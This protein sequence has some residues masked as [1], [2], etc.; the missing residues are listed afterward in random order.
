[1]DS[2]AIKQGMSR[3]GARAM[4]KATGLK[5]ADIAKP[6]I[7]VA[8]TWTDVTPCSINQRQVAEWVKR[9]VREAGGTPLEF[10]TI[11]VT[12]GICMG[13]EGM[14][15][16]LISREVVADSIELVVRG[17][18]LDGVVAISGCDKTIPGTVMALLRLDLPGLM[19][20]SGSILPGY[21]NGKA[22]T[23]QDV[24]E[25]IGACAAGKIGE[26]ELKALEDNACPGAGACGGQFTANTM[27][28]AMTL[29]GIS[30]MGMSDIP[31]VDPDK[32]NAAVEAGRLVMKLLKAG[33]TPRK[34]VTRKAVENAITAVM[35]SG[36]STNGVLHL[37]AIAREAGLPLDLSD[38]D[39]ISKRSPIITDLKPWGKYVALDVQK[40]GGVRLFTKRLLDGGLL[41]DELTVTGRR[42]S[43]EAA[44]AKETPGQQV[45]LTLEKPY[46][47]EGGIHIL[48]G[49]LAP[50]GCVIKVSGQSRDRHVGPARVF[51]GEEAA[52]KAVQSRKIKPGDVV[53]IRYEGPRGGPGMREML[54][55]TGAIQGQGLGK[56]VALVTD[57]RFSGA[58]HGFMVGHV[59]PEA[60]VG[61]P[62]AFLKDG[63]EIT[64]DVKTRTLGVTADLKKRAKGWKAPKPAY[65]SGVMA[66]YA[67][68]V[69]SASEGAVTL[70]IWND[71]GSN[72]RKAL[73]GKGRKAQ[74]ARR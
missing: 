54:A 47:K 35:S 69:S 20:Y 60:A 68:S 43:E 45:I 64:I 6:L 5:D 15:A 16:S 25:G 57:G 13:T 23:I 22:I 41:K 48:R 50:E 31:A 24:Y 37:L 73:L 12:D 38:F 2:D 21:L 42:L 11:T 39:R 17:H 67:A 52:F 36:G 44:E 53:V 58:T 18:L 19:I 7:A 70:P 14:K 34:V 32:Q 55:V 3:A 4:W 26:S 61:G 30:P 27:A 1:M 59:A 63:D 8:H 62:I 51:D 66:K 9:G 74:G 10:N 40:A 71:G 33:I 28:M 72:G 49:N 46:K 29:L 65:T 56:D